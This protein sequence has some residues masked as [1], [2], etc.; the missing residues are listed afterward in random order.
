MSKK[1]AAGSGSSDDSP[2]AW[3]VQLLTKFE[4]VKT[5]VATFDARHSAFD[6]RLA[7]V[8]TQ[9]A[10]VKTTVATF[11]ARLT[12]SE[13]AYETTQAAIFAIADAAKTTAEEGRAIAAN[14][15]AASTAATVA[16]SPRERAP[17]R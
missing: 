9:L 5:T 8:T 4:D 10:E 11:E 1:G 12:S 16:A 13:K 7:E 17:L 14:A 6:A 2:P 3:A 15:E